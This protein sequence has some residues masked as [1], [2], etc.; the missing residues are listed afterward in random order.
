MVCSAVERDLDIS[1]IFLAS[2]N[3]QLVKETAWSV[4]DITKLNCLI[5]KSHIFK[6]KKLIFFIEMYLII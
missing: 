2:C 6:L 3:M 1:E 4:N 5:K